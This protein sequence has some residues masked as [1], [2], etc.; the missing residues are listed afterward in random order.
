MIEGLGTTIDRVLLNGKLHQGDKIVV[1]G[2][3]GPIVT[4]I[5]ALLTPHPMKELRVKTPYQHHDVMPAAMGIKIA[6]QGLEHAVA[7]TSILVCD[8]DDDLEDLM[9]EVQ[10]GK[11]GCGWLVSWVDGSFDAV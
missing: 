7:G 5:R 6:G 10:E 8:D 2:M 11:R 9:A 3:E 1:C 4:T